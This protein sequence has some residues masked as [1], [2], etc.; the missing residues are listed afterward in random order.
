MAP[1]PSWVLGVQQPGVFYPNTY[2]P[3]RLHSANADPTLQ[4]QQPH[5]FQ[6]SFDPFDQSGE[7]LS[8]QTPPRSHGTAAEKSPSPYRLIPYQQGFSTPAP[9]LQRQPQSQQQ[10]QQFHR[11][12]PAFQQQPTYQPQYQIQHPTIGFPSFRDDQDQRSPQ[13]VAGVGFTSQG[14]PFIS[15][16]GSQLTANPT[17][18]RGFGAGIIT[19]DPRS[20][21]LQYTFTDSG[22]VQ[23]PTPDPPRGFALPSRGTPQ[24]TQQQQQNTPQPASSPIPR[25]SPVIPLSPSVDE[26]DGEVVALIPHIP[27]GFSVL[28]TPPEQPRIPVRTRVPSLPVTPQDRDPRLLL[29]YPAKPEEDAAGPPTVVDQ[30]LDAEEEEGGS[31]EKSR[32]PEESNREKGVTRGRG[33][34]EGELRKKP[35][36]RAQPG[37]TGNRLTPV[38]GGDHVRAVA[39]VEGRNGPEGG[40]GRLEGV[41]KEDSVTERPRYGPGGRRYKG[42]G[43]RRIRPKQTVSSTED[44]L[45]AVSPSTFRPRGRF[46]PQKRVRPQ[47]VA[48]GAISTSTT[49]EEVETE[50]PT[51]TTTTT[52]T[53]TPA[54]IITT[55]PP[56]N[57][58]A[59]SIGAEEEHVEGVEGTHQQ[60][61]VEIPDHDESIDVSEHEPS[62]EVSSEED[63]V[64]EHE[65]DYDGSFSHEHDGG[66]H[67]SQEEHDEEA[68][69]PVPWHEENDQQGNETHA[70]NL[71]ED[72]RPATEDKGE[73]YHVITMK[74][75]GQLVSQENFK[76]F[77][78]SADIDVTDTTK[79]PN[80]DDTGITEETETVSVSVSRGVSLAAASSSPPQA[81]PPPQPVISVVTTKSIVAATPPP[82]PEV[83]TTEGWVIVA[84]VQTSRSVS[85]AR[86]PHSSLGDHNSVTSTTRP[87]T[88]PL[89]P[90][91]STPTSSSTPSSTESII[92]KLDRVQSELSTG[93]LTGGFRSNLRPL[94]IRGMTHES[95]ESSTA[96]STTTA[97][98]TESTSVTP[99][100]ASPSTTS[101]V[102]VFIR[103]FSPSN[104]R[105]STTTHAPSTARTPTPRKIGGARRP[106][107]LDSVKFEDDL[108]GLLP[109]GF[110]PRG[111]K[112]RPG[113]TTESPS[114]TSTTP[115]TST[116]E[117]P[118]KGATATLQGKHVVFD[119]IKSLLPPGY[120]PSK[121]QEKAQTGPIFRPS[122]KNSSSFS[123][124]NP[125]TPSTTTTQ[126]SSGLE[127][128]L[129]KIKFADVTSLLPSGYQ[130]KKESSVDLSSLLP[131]GYKPPEETPQKNRS[132]SL[133]PKGVDLT[134]LLPAGYKPPKEEDTLGSITKVNVS[135]LLPPGYNAA[136]AGNTTSDANSTVPSAPQESEDSGHT[137][138][139]FPSRPGGRKPPRK[140]TP[141]PANNGPPKP[142]IMK[143]WPTRA[144]TEFTGWPTS[145]TTPISVERILEQARKAAAAVAAANAAATDPPSTLKPRGSA[146][147][148]SVGEG[149]PSGESPSA[150]DEAAEDITT[151]TTTTTEPTTPGVCWERCELI[152][153]IKLVGG[154]V[155]G[156]GTSG[157]VQATWRPELM[158]HLT[159]EWKDLANA[160]ANE[161]EAVYSSSEGL[162]KWYK[163]VRIDGFRE[164]SVV[165]DYVVELKEVARRV[166]TAELKRLFNDALGK[167]EKIP[168]PA[169][170]TEATA[171]QGRSVGD[172][173]LDARRRPQEMEVKRLG[174]FLVDPEFTD[175][176]VITEDQGFSR[177][178]GRGLSWPGGS[179]NGD[180]EE[181]VEAVPQ[182]AV[183]VIVIGLASLVF[184]VGFGVTVLVNRQKNAKKRREQQATPLT[185][186]ILREMGKG[187]P[188]SGGGGGSFA[189]HPASG[190]GSFG[191][192]GAGFDNYGAD[193]DLEDLYD[194]D[195]VWNDR[196]HEKKRPPSNSGGIKRPSSTTG[197]SY[198]GSNGGVPNGSR[199]RPP[200]AG[201][202]DSWR[203]EWNDYYFNAYYGGGLGGGVGGGSISNGRRRTTPDYDTNF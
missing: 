146:S 163:R 54:P 59:E 16:T 95:L 10:Q 200:E 64:P 47:N 17:S 199:F 100:P 91:E 61:G 176:K 105:T 106:S 19:Q 8:F 67:H 178:G 90:S 151:T 134:S 75:S 182:W 44:T 76:G 34:G 173:T 102:P 66:D 129:S 60:P 81:T 149:G 109:A 110:K 73:G 37:T 162:R 97:S 104:R 193:T 112:K 190:G 79:A 63:H 85:G 196:S 18:G 53:T 185:D 70:E 152:G 57:Y 80:V 68:E 150:V 177:G 46:S 58:D 11:Q 4:P 192:G 142:K 184:V 139:V 116:T 187:Q 7:P 99:S 191:G 13:S 115:P 130:E 153:L 69:D 56:D 194:M 179:V 23:R 201:H 123:P 52:T 42:G 171:A 49:T 77:V 55:L 136:A 157:G 39:E 38:R 154:S 5:R 160:V 25:P 186:E 15:Q 180:G 141:R 43:V 35:G 96:E 78:D 127:S 89:P 119:D 74:P 128:I 48:F 172:P 111:F 45:S 65:E 121:A 32:R 93:L 170:T 167:G 165:V 84:S 31:V 62:A 103:K 3:F 169:A 2:I 198:A 82:P 9:S 166:D 20:G 137:R 94:G 181:I 168:L 30:N 86:R 188:M 197:N 147:S 27:S 24:R 1:D 101:S 203:T 118:G 40:R 161:L 72:E 155:G 164:G 125:T 12:P 148:S 33:R 140:T 50:P 14:F 132:T 71:S 29:G 6:H 131:K 41:T 124:G 21:K 108:S 113:P 174:G 88:T 156:N 107:I 158:N 133:R 114:T 120:N 159:H 145:S 117:T 143:G 26:G 98:T 195:D 28:P 183:A 144:T 36:N 175:F 126:K 189:G 22:L 92:D 83:P 138:V 135:S 202:Y 87:P 122:L 51:T